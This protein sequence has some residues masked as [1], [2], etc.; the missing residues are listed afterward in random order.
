MS[1]HFVIWQLPALE[2][3]DQKRAGNI[4]QISGFLSGQ[5]GVERHQR[6]RIAFGKLR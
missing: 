3:R 5:L 6:Y 2:Q 1:A 4:E